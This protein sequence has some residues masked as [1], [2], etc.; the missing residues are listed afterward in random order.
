MEITDEDTE[1]E[2]K[3][4]LEMLKAYHWKLEERY[5]RINFATERNLI[6]YKKVQQQGNINFNLYKEKKFTKEEKDI[7]KKYKKFARFFNNMEEYES[8][9]KSLYEEEIIK[10]KINDLKHYRSLGK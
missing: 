10:K 5:K 6:D 1:Q 3:L 9:T 4:K 7:D 8:F 2:K